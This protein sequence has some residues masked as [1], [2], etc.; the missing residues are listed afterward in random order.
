MPRFHGRGV[1]QKFFQDIPLQ[2]KHFSFL[3]GRGVIVPEAMQDSMEQKQT[4]FISR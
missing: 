2:G 3:L 1:A 4:Q